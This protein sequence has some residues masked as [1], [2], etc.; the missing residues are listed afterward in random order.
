MVML[1]MQRWF[2]FAATFC[3]ILTIEASEMGRALP[4]RSERK[5]IFVSCEHYKFLQQQ[6]AELQKTVVA[7]EQIIAK[8]SKEVAILQEAYSRAVDVESLKDLQDD[9]L[10]YDADDES[11]VG[12][13]EKEA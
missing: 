3:M 9:F 2:I 12:Q 4:K 7:N 5:A 13:L 6:I 10:D 1:N 8:L 11:A